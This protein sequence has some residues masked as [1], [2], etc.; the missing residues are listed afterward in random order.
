MSDPDN[1][2]NVMIEI[3]RK[4]KLGLL[5]DVEELDDLVDNMQFETDKEE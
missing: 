4:K 1:W 5:E 3:E 2:S